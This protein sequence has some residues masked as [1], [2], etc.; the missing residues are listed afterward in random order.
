[1]VAG[2][3]ELT[4]YTTRFTPF[5]SFAI[6]FQH[7]GRIIERCLRLLSCR[8]AGGRTDYQ[9]IHDDAGNIIRVPLHHE[10]LIAGNRRQVGILRQ[11]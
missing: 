11:A 6:R 5:T 1:M 10:D 4:S 7:V 9:S 8:S 3:F 2:G